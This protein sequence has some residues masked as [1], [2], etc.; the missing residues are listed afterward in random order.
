MPPKKV[1][2]KNPK[3][4]PI[5]IQ[6]SDLSISVSPPPSPAIR[7]SP[8]SLYHTEALISN[9][10]S[11]GKKNIILLAGYPGSGKSRIVEEI[12]N[13][14]GEQ[15]ILISGDHAEGD[16]GQ[17]KYFS[18]SNFD[19]VADLLEENISKWPDMSIIIDKPFLSVERGA[20]NPNPEI[21]GWAEQMRIA[22]PDANI[23]IS[24]LDIPKNGAIDLMTNR[25]KTNESRGLIPKPLYN[26]Y[27]TFIENTYHNSDFIRRVIKN[28]G[29]KYIPLHVNEDVLSTILGQP[30]GKKSRKKVRRRV[31]KTRRR[32][33]SQYKYK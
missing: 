30:G 32:N 23:V 12:I 24:L 13:K 7:P 14:C 17:Y 5:R 2:E 21:L 6:T 8:P 10:K 33:K 16:V 20:D 1:S 27:E 31:K 26:G 22:F 19:T 15:H 29:Y 28:A 9:L 11:S 3:Q 25:W 4:T 18:H